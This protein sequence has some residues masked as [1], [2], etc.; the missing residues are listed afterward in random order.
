MARTEP[1]GRTEPR[2]LVHIACASGLMVCFGKPDGG[3]RKYEPVQIAA[4]TSPGRGARTAR[5]V[6]ST[7]C[8]SQ[9]AYVMAANRA[10]WQNHPRGDRI[11]PERGAATSSG[12]APAVVET[13]TTGL[14]QRENEN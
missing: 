7:I 12:R 3:N 8:H 2:E 13:L 10:G 5:G 6:L 14:G 4:H 1:I 9:P 11:T